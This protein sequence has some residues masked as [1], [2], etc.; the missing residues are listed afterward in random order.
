MKFA[1]LSNDVVPGMGLPASGQGIR[2]LCTQRLLEELGWTAD[3]FMQFSLVSERYRRWS[4]LP[5]FKVPSSVQLYR[6]VEARER[7]AE[8]DTIVLHNWGAGQKLQLLDHPPGRLIYDFFSATLVEHEF[9]D[10]GEAYLEDVAQRKNRLLKPASAFWGNG[11]G[12]VDYATAYLERQ[13]ITGQPVWNV[14]MSPEC[15]ENTRERLIVVGGFR[16]AWTTT[17]SD[18]MLD[19]I[20]ETFADYEVVR[21]GHGIQ[22]HGLKLA[23]VDADAEAVSARRFFDLNP[24]TFA[25]YERLLRRASLFIDLSDLNAERRVS[26]SSRGLTALAMG[27]PILHNRE[28]DLGALVEAFEAGACLAEDALG[29]EEAL[30]EAVRRCV[31]VD[32]REAAHGLVRHLEDTARENI[33]RSVEGAG[34]TD[35]TRAAD[36]NA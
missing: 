34:S 12:R 5:G 17:L 29:S 23:P 30:L 24:M 13:G 28:T 1:I 20:A 11:T 4:E 2:A 31:A 27:C 26:F 36:A 15:Q 16:Q 21:L 19:R 33:A 9:L 6:A 14:P 8:Y 3:V 22:Y 18:R 25:D 7:L 35:M 32:R 10:K